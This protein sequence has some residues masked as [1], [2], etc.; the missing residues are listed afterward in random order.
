MG[1]ASLLQSLA[2]DAE[3][4]AGMLHT[5]APEVPRPLQVLH[6]CAPLICSRNSSARHDL[7]KALEEHAAT[8][9]HI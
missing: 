3:K 4:A 8:H 2:G 1:S 7:P 5:L 6:K 9:C